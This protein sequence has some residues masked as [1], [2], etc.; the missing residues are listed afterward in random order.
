MEEHFTKILEELGL[1]LQD[2]SLA[3]T[4]KRLAKMY[5]EEIFTGL[6]PDNFPKVS[7]FE[8]DSPLEIQVKDISFVSFCE[9]HFLPIFGKATITYTPKGKILGL[10]SIH[11]IVHFYAKRPQLQ[12]RLTQQ[13]GECFERYL[14]TPDVKVE[15]EGEHSCVRARGVLDQSS[16]MKTCY[17]PSRLSSLIT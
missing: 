13:I 3:R 8:T 6:Q 17:V 4:P 12:E 7:L 15:I 5:K 16:T 10:S 11:E 14:E 1:D 9:H 2:P